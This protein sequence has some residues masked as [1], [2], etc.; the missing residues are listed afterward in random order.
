MRRAIY[1]LA[2]LSDSLL[3]E[4]L[5]EGMPLIVNNA[6]SLDTTAHRLYR[7]KEFRAAEIMR[8]FAEEEAAKFLILVD[9]VCC[10]RASGLR[11]RTLKRFYDHVQKRVYALTCS[12]PRI[13]S[14]SELSELV[15][16]ECRF[17]YLD[18]P[19]WVDWIHPNAIS[20]E[21]ERSMYVDYIQDITTEPGEYH[22]MA[23]FDWPQPSSPND[24]PD[25]VRL[26][27]A[28]LD[29]GVSSPEG[30]AVIADHWRK[31]DPR[32]DADRGELWNLIDH[33]LNCLT[34]HGVGK[35]DEATIQ[36]IVTHWSFPMWPL[37][38]REPHTKAETLQ[39]LREE[40]DLAIKRINET[41]EKRD[42]P[43][44]ISRAKVEQLNEAYDTWQRDVDARIAC[45]TE[46][47]ST[48]LR[49]RSSA[50]IEEDYRLPS[51][52]RLKD[53]FSQLTGKERAALLA[54]AWYT[55][56][57]VADWPRI[58]ESA[59]KREPTCNENYQIGCACDWLAGLNR[60]EKKPQPFQAG[61][62]RRLR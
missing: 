30:L 49:I 55:R 23:P 13:A 17:Y 6:I 61:Q 16:K 18:G 14:F 32:P 27:R 60:W 42:P 29:A 4:E 39:L 53:L 26:S 3:F 20:A 11:E 44:A 31:F 1:D 54:L 5:S 52:A 9:F 37:T 48:G 41:D 59:T 12:Y 47:K 38:M 24:T 51:Y 7:E 22:W 56:E 25:C 46:N 19:N 21:R 36:L 2:Q 62:L 58:Y 15:D 35:L 8:G 50:D 45:N 43:P 28:L 40:R 57:R 10:P 33:T 34:Q